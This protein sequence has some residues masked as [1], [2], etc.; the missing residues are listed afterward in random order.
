MHK[1]SETL[2]IY[3]WKHIGLPTYKC[4]NNTSYCQRHIKYFFFSFYIFS[5]INK[6][7]IS[8]K[9]RHQSYFRADEYNFEVKT[10]TFRYSYHKDQNALPQI[11][12]MMGPVL[13]NMW[14]TYKNLW[15]LK[16]L[17]ICYSHPSC[18]S[19]IHCTWPMICSSMLKFS[20]K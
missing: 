1:T 19:L 17:P 16:P 2:S 12:K 9:C 4:K 14:C 20:F 5:R 18:S 7:K 3:N 15:V 11:T 8:G 13:L 10:S 6:F